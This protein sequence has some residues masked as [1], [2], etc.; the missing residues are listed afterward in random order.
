MYPEH[1]V[2]FLVLWRYV[3]SVFQ[4]LTHSK[5]RKNLSASKSF[6]KVLSLTFFAF[7][8][9]I[10]F[11]EVPH[12][13]VNPASHLKMHSGKSNCWSLIAFIRFLKRHST[14]VK[15]KHSELIFS[16]RLSQTKSILIKFA[17]PLL[18]FNF[19]CWTNTLCSYF[20]YSNFL[21]HRSGKIFEAFL[22]KSS[23]N[24]STVLCQSLSELCTSWAC[25]R[26]AILQASRRNLFRSLFNLS[27][28]QTFSPFFSDWIAGFLG[29]FFRW[30]EPFIFFWRCFS[31]DSY[32]PFRSASA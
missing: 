17:I 4:Q 1:M 13:H 26:F 21:D 30:L 2:R 31:S 16:P 3:T 22:F 27:G 19:W 24:R 11:L 28:V 25:S 15:S 29:N 7:L 5:F 23:L 10:S 18:W 9:V 6:S 8:S 20:S 14:D 12:L 32:D